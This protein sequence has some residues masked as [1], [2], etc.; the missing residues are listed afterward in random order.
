MSLTEEDLANL[1][2]RMADLK[3]PVTLGD[4]GDYYEV[5]WDFV[6]DFGIKPT[7]GGWPSAD[8]QKY[9]RQMAR[10]WE[11]AFYLCSDAHFLKN[12][13]TS[14]VKQG[15]NMRTEMV[16]QLATSKNSPCTVWI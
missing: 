3:L 10:A 9:H 16:D 15:K 14:L 1:A 12:Q 2:R 8:A 6:R 11:A 7:H 5:E 4:I 13:L